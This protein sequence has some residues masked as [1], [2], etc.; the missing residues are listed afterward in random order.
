MFFDPSPLSTLFTLRTQGAFAPESALEVDGQDGA[1]EF[2]HCWCRSSQLLRAEVM[3]ACAVDCELHSPSAQERGLNQGVQAP[4]L[5]PSLL[6][7]L[8]HP[9][10]EPSET[11]VALLGGLWPKPI[12]PKAWPLFLSQHETPAPPPP[13]SWRTTE[14][15][16]KH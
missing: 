13:P 12:L 8:A 4:L 5:P 9:C 3:T 16:F 7:D 11:S 2:P 10:L 14:G 1:P 6:Q 15:S